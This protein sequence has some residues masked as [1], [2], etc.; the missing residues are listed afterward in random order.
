MAF[1]FA[2]SGN[3]CKIGSA[4]CQVIY[5]PVLLEFN[6]W[7]PIYPFLISMIHYDGHNDHDG[8][9][10]HQPRGCL[11]NRLF[12]R[13]S[14]KTLKLRVTGLCVGNSPGPVNSPHKGPVTRKMF[15]FDDVI[16]RDIESQIQWDMLNTLHRDDA[17]ERH[18]W[19]F[20]TIEI[21]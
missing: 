8:G 6:G 17:K 13:K 11:L 14:K 18:T 21:K 16:M 10:N 19:D 5:Q 9:S 2:Q 7:F 1:R 20:F 15:P 3:A 4:H 12:R